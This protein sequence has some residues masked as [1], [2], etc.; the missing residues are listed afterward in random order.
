MMHASS[1]KDA[2]S[3]ALH[4]TL[5]AA[6]PPIRLLLCMQLVIDNAEMLR[7]T[8]QRE[9]YEASKDRTRDATAEQQLAACP[10]DSQLRPE[11]SSDAQDRMVAS[12][13]AATCLPNNLLQGFEILWVSPHGS[14]LYEES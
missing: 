5:S 3:S 4:A 1:A 13:A 6:L 14:S 11:S 12:D 8:Q 9:A 2:G 10:E 7:S